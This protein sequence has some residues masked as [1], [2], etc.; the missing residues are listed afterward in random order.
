AP[1]ALDAALDVGAARNHRL[2]V[3]SNGIAVGC[4][5]GKWQLAPALAGVD[6]QLAEQTRDLRR[7]AAL[8]H[9]IE[10][11]KP[12][13]SF[14]RVELRGVFRSNVSHGTHVLSLGN[15]VRLPRRSRLQANHILYTDDR[16]SYPRGKL[17]ERFDCHEVTKV[18]KRKN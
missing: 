16:G 9:V 12:F 18:T 4:I 10:R 17:H 14:D 6:G 1:E 5:G 11:I 8:Q 13:A 2:V 15:V 7:P 3:G